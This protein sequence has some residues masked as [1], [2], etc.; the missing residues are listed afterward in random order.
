M[1]LKLSSELPKKTKVME[2]A[3]GDL[4][5]TSITANARRALMGK[6]KENE[7]AKQEMFFFLP[8][9]LSRDDQN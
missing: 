7:K 6:A 4:E 8:L 9:F 5:T 3:I 1:I 2:C